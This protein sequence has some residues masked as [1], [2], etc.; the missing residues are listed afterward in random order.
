MVKIVSVEQ[1]RQIEAAADASGISYATMMQ[2]AGRA[3]AHRAL[4]L[5]ADQAEPRITVLV[6][7]GNNGGDGLV[8][9]RVI[10]QESS[11]L[12]RCYLLRRRDDDL[13]LEEAQAAGVRVAHA[14]DD[15]GYRVLRQ[16]VGSAH[17]LL[18]ALFGIGIR[19]PLQGE[20]ARL[21]QITGS[22]LAEA[23]GLRPESRLLTPV[24]PTPREA[25]PR[26]PYV[27]AVDC[28]SGLNCDTGQ[29][30]QHTLAADE[31]ITFI[32]AKPGLL[33]FPGAGVTGELA[34]ATLGI[35]ADLPE[36]AAA[37]T[38]LADA[39]EI[40]RRLPA[41]PPNSHKGTYGKALVIGG[42]E[43]YRGAIALAMRAA[44]RTGAGLV[45][46]CAP[47]SVI[48]AMA[49]QVQEATW[50][51]RPQ[52]EAQ[53]PGDYDTLLIGPGW[54]R[55]EA[56]RALLDHLL[57]QKLPPLII[58]ADGLNLLSD[59]PD[60]WT[61]LPPHAIITPHPGEMA[62]LSGL[63]TTEIQ[64]DRHN[65][66]IQK[67]AEW[68]VILLL[69]GAHTII[70]APDGRVALLPFKTDALAKAGTG[71]VLAGVIAGFA[72]QGLDAFDAALVGGYVH[73]LAG[74][75]AAA[76]CQT[77]RSVLASDVVEHLAPALMHL[78]RHSP[79]QA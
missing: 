2:N 52:A 43:N 11:A 7:T 34:V 44:Y 71:D 59:Q 10:A 25:T 75:L 77:T 24:Q 73:G 20:A 1:M 45:T 64:A 30:D 14:T 49:G 53:L 62:R 5:L 42:S 48:H 18:D 70:A 50:L 33:T 72:A 46:G 39:D 37:N 79:I 15:Q 67:A 31:T 16:M 65:I 3:T 6:G 17:L 76:T 21:L 69:K 35:P 8:A 12:V 58:D 32:A 54:S 19:L 26:F 68:Q 41:R 60:W 57:A 4:R 63:P 38:L 36:L 78:E 40:R 28:P 74:R 22:T 51:P 29:V 61:R 56:N 9:A 47:E 55:A 13:L 27:L 23:R 66:A